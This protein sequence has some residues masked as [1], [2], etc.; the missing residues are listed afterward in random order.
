VDGSPTPNAPCRHKP[1]REWSMLHH[2]PF[3]TR[4]GSQ[5]GL[6]DHPLPGSYENMMIALEAVIN[7]QHRPSRAR[8]VNINGAG[9]P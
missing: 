6:A 9:A 1:V 5:K 3:G 4:L 2:G 8:K 7:N